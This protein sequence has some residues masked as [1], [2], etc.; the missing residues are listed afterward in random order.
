MSGRFGHGLQGDLK[1]DAQYLSNW[2]VPNEQ[3]FNM[4]SEEVES[5][6]NTE[7]VRVVKQILVTCRLREAKEAGGRC[8]FLGVP[9]AWNKK[10]D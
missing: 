6:T 10:S 7:Q 4:F 2:Q 9:S 3:S 5:T 1:I 8:V